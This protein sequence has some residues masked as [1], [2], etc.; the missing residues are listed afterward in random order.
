[1]RLTNRVVNTLPCRNYRILLQL[2]A[3]FT[4]SILDFLIFVLRLLLRLS[5]SPAAI[6]LMNT[7]S[8]GDVCSELILLSILYP[9]VLLIHSITLHV[10][11]VI[12]VLLSRRRDTKNKPFLMKSDY[13]TVSCS[14]RSFGFAYVSVVASFDRCRRELESLRSVVTPTRGGSGTTAP[15]NSNGGEQLSPN[16]DQHPFPQLPSPHHAVAGP[17]PG[18]APLAQPAAQ[19]IPMPELVHLPNPF[20]PQPALTLAGGEPLSSSQSLQLQ[21]G[22]FHSNALKPNVSTVQL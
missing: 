22:S 11:S 16:F 4:F 21:S 17:A 7:R 12:S 15:S 14:V 1:M 8:V 6:H 3:P 10:T 2:E 9:S 13:W 18:G 20:P 19:N 5:F